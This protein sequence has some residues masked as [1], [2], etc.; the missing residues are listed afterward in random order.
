M[1][2][3]QKKTRVFNGK[4]YIHWKLFRSH[5]MAKQE[6]KKLGK[7]KYCRIVERNYG[8]DVYTRS[9]RK[10]TTKRKVL[11]FKMSELLVQ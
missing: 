7:T 6:C 10:K 4:K 1:V 3:V 8:F 2:G 5:S 11:V 9:K